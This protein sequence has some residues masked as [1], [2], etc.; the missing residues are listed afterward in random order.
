[1]I[2]I[3][4]LFSVGQRCNSPDFLKYYSLRN[5]SGPFDYLYIDI[6]T[7]FDNI[8]NEFNLFFKDIVSF[9]KK[10]NKLVIHNS[11][12]DIKDELHQLK[13]YE[14]IYYVAQDYNNTMLNI[15]QN[16][17]DNLSNNLYEW[18]RIFISSHHDLKNIKIHNMIKERSEIFLNIYKNIPLNMILFHITKIFEEDNINKYKKYIF[19]LKTK[20]NIQSYLIIIIC[21]DKIEE[22]ECFENNVL[23]IV[24]KVKSYQEQYKLK[25]VDNNRLK[26]PREINIINK[27]F[28]LNLKTYEEIKLEYSVKHFI[29]HRKLI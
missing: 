23:F 2:E 16:Y 9:K 20:Y 21:A 19:D 1:M 6:E 8:K 24:K 15:N 28:N 17:I 3:N 29:N 5:I 14:N 4:Y 13:K 26:Y 11:H 12:K 10:D 22:N 18:K 27:Y 7:C 25:G